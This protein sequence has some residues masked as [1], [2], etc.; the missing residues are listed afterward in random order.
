M[1][2]GCVALAMDAKES[3]TWE[4]SL[5]AQSSYL[6]SRGHPDAN[7]ELSGD[8]QS[9]K[10]LRVLT[11]ATWSEGAERQLL[12]AEPSSLFSPDLTSSKAL[13]PRWRRGH[14]PGVR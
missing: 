14:S 9:V 10:A 4:R 7:A 11:R 8:K 12:M 1:A 2:G 13:S 3:A 5:D 6:L